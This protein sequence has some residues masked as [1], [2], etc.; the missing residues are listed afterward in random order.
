MKTIARILVLGG[1]AA[2]ALN[3]AAQ[4]T[5]SGYFLENYTY[6]YQLNPAM[7]NEKGFVSLPALG[8][9]NTTV[10]GN[11]H[12]K[13]VIYNVKG[14]T[15]LF[16]NPD[17]SVS[18]VMNGLS[19]KNRLGF[20]LRENILSVGFKAF[21]G[22][23]TVSINARAEANIV[24]PKSLFSLAKEG[25]T[26]KT[27]D[28]KDLYASA[29]GYAE[30]ALNHSHEIA[31]VDG[32]RVGGTIKFLIPIADIDA[33]FNDAHLT[34]GEDGWTALTNA[35]VY[36]NA[37]KFQFEKK[38]NND[39][40]EYVSGGNLDGTGSLTQGFGVAFDLGATYDWNDFRFS[41]AVLDLGW[42]NLSNSHYASTEGDRIVNTDKY[43]FSA[44]GNSEHKFK[45]EWEALRDGLE[46]LYQLT[47]LEN[48]NSRN[49]TMAATLNVGVEYIFPMY[50]RL[51]FGLLSSTRFAGRYTWTEAR[52]SAN[53]KPVNCF[54]ADANVAVGTYGTSFGW[55]AN[56]HFTGFNFFL[57]MDH[58]LGK[59][60]KQF[61]PLSSNA[62]V[63]LG[64]NF[65][66]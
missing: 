35:E 44:D 33:R 23:N 52:L 19:D 8:N 56:L 51:H 58:T 15:C 14:K 43:I 50:R 9:L 55:M 27:Y 60:T 5:N 24:V 22:Y 10:R 66:F 53:V 3:S 46:S 40:K 36:V 42:M 48:V 25:V 29:L 61:V 63:T 38:R 1:F 13:N 21:H 30:I 45:K 65:P 31:P 37:P 4:T 12:L 7:G 2:F 28:I 59:V 39:N 16:T 11:L 26:N 47:K 64:F 17:V 62:S 49:H 18:D 32:L 20:N 57:G 34:L 41:A 54:S 6:R